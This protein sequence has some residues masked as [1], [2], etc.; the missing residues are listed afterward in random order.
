MAPCPRHRRGARLP[1]SACS[2]P[3]PERRCSHGSYGRSARR[4][5]ERLPANRLESRCGFSLLGRTSLRRRAP[6]RGRSA[7]SRPT[8]FDSST[9]STR[10]SVETRSA[11][12]HR[13]ARSSANRPRLPACADR[14]PVA[15][16]THR[17]GDRERVL[18][19]V[20]RGD[21]R[22]G[23]DRAAVRRRRSRGIQ[24]PRQLREF[25]EITVAGIIRAVRRRQGG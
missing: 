12:P 21:D 8:A 19:A 6:P 2:P 10:L 15:R 7:S 25:S 14:V 13:S 22:R 9:R 4:D 5:L 17:T 24:L 11:T 3:S 18:H 1:P 20:G 23:R 16:R